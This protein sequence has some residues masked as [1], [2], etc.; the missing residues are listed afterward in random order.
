MTIGAWSR[1]EY[2]EVPKARHAQSTWQK[3]A[4]RKLDERT[5]WVELEAAPTK[6]KHLLNA[7]VWSHRFTSV[8]ECC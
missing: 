2:K 4:V 1:I 6:I 3:L 7:P 5:R 8:I